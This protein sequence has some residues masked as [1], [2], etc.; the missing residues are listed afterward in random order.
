MKRLLRTLKIILTAL[1]ILF[2]IFYFYIIY[3][4]WGIPFNAQRHTQVPLTP[5]W[6]LECW[7]WEDD[8]NSATRVDELLDGYA[9][10][11]I[12]VR[13]I[14]LDSPWS[15]R[16]NDFIFD[17]QRYPNPIEWL[18]KLDKQGYRVV[19]WMTCMVNSYNK[20]TAIRNSQEWFQ[21]ARNKNILVG[22]GFQV[23]WWKG[24][25][26]FIDYTNPEAMNWWQQ[27]QQKLFD[28]GIDGWKLDG[29]ATFF[30]G[31]LGFLPVPYQRTHQG[32]MTTRHYMDYYYREEYRHGLRHNPEFV[33]LVRPID[34]PYI[35]PEGYAPFDAAPV[36]WVGDQ[37]HTWEAGDGSADDTSAT[38]DLIMYGAGG[39]TA[40]IEKILMSAKL[41]YCVIGSDIAGFSGATI[42]PRLY[43][44]WA[45]LS[46]FCGLF[47]NGGHGER[48]LWKRSR[49]ELEIIRKFAWLHTE[50]IPY[51]Y[52]YVV[53]CHQ[54]E[55]PLQRPVKGRYHFM[56]GEDFLVAPI[57]RDSYTRTVTLPPGKWRYLFDDH[58]LIDGPQQ[59]TRD[60]P[61]TEYP[62]FIREGAIIPVN[63]RRHYTGWG[64]STATGYLTWLIYPAEQNK[65]NLYH[66]DK[67][68]QT[69]VQTFYKKNKLIIEFSGIK[70]PH[71]LRIYS[72][73]QPLS[74]MLDE[75]LLNQAQDWWYDV[76]DQR[77]RIKTEDYQQGRYVI[78]WR[79]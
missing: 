52:S 57:F 35:H 21:A 16:Y 78:F 19:L 59:L 34:S 56:F 74:V 70:K 13:T 71:I 27:P 60:F 12:P 25:G 36:T 17:E 51:M 22:N 58:F 46:A 67:S 6:A 1:G 53:R 42:P 4:L 47:L 15:S 38:D 3:P 9:R 33:T 49:T 41:G 10:H 39:I 68:G 18:R 72:S 54:G 79:D 64:D 29:T 77:L 11:D 2:L 62:V 43:I 45:Q 5:A 66:P 31:K 24:R 32:W 73:S 65:F 7:L 30:R 20:D 37:R 63:V 44:R 50:L 48:A 55:P 61:L 14:L 75:S 28:A 40:A 8:E 23:S 26:G 76:S 69:T